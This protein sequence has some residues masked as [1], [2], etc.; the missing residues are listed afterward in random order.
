MFPLE[1]RILVIDDM[2][3][4]RDLVKNTLKAM[5]FKNI[6][7]AGDGEEGLKVLMQSN[8]PGSSI[9]LVISDWNMPKMKGLDLLKHVRATSEWQNLPFVLLTSE[10][11]RD[12]V[13]E[14][15][16]A[17]VSQYIVK[18]FSAKI[19]EDKLKAAWT[20]HNQK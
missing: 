17:G 10:S 11:E 19:F 6:Q 2:P 15:V 14:A 8:N 7:E 20:K 16:L 13:T 12:Q 5:G 3:S 1:T 4:I 9:Q 18:P